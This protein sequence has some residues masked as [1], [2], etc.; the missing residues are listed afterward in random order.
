MNPACE[1]AHGVW[2]R[3]DRR[4]RQECGHGARHPLAYAPLRDE[5]KEQDGGRREAE[6]CG[7]GGV[8]EAGRKEVGRGVEQP[9]PGRELAEPDDPEAAQDHHAGAGNEPTAPDASGADEECQ[10]C[11][12]Q[13]NPDAHAC[14]LEETEFHLSRGGNE[15]ARHEQRSPPIE[16]QELIVARHAGGGHD[17]E[18]FRDLAAGEAL[19]EPAHEVV[20][21]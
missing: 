5:D 15:R 18:P 1:R 7:V 14:A 4:G 19:R 20:R 12:Q 16:V 8:R 13:R 21:R 11:E 2:S 17:L 3:H 10:E 6:R 9:R